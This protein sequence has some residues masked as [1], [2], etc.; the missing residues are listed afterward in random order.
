MFP[1]YFLSPLFWTIIEGNINIFSSCTSPPF[2]SIRRC[3]SFMNDTKG[4]YLYYL[5]TIPVR[6]VLPM[7]YTGSVCKKA[8][9]CRHE[10]TV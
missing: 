7:L 1:Y 8:E 2:L 5:R 3:L 9:K 10:R 4:R 6:V